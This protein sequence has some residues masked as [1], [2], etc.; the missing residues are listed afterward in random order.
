MFPRSRGHGLE[1][2]WI[3]TAGGV[4]GG[5]RFLN[6]FNVGPGAA[7]SLT[8]QAAERAY[9]A[10]PGETGVL[11]T[12]IT[13]EAGA[14]LHWMPQETILFQGCALERSLRVDLADGAGA[15]IV[16]PVIFGRA[17]MGERL[18]Q[19]HFRDRI[20]VW[21][22]GAPLFTDATRLSGEIAAHLARPTIAAGA[23]AMALV[24]YVGAGAEAHLAPVRSEL[25][26][27]SGASLIRQDAVCLRLLAADG[28]ELRRSLIPV[29]TRLSGGALPRTWMF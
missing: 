19:G 12:R 3:N 13:V 6:E 20:E 15:L 5:D 26:A 22:E 9:R 10:Q 8:S 7:L 28:Y 2:V 16:E 27:T 18:E 23:G 17:A 4:T 25:N 24:L 1:A 11:R 21:R 14:R 29:L